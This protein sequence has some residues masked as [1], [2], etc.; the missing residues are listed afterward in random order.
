MGVIGHSPPGIHTQLCRASVVGNSMGMV[1]PLQ[2]SLVLAGD[3]S[4]S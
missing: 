3:L 2:Y 1:G 4:Q